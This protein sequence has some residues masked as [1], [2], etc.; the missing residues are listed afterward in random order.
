M[1]NYS[2]VTMLSKLQ[3]SYL[4]ILGGILITI[5]QV[6]SANVDGLVWWIIYKKRDHCPDKPFI[7]WVVVAIPQSETNQ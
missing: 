5:V 1:N 3:K 2:L 6:A 4:G 7:T